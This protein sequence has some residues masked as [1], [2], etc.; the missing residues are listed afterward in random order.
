MPCV[1]VCVC[2]CTHVLCSVMSDSATPQAVASWVPLSMK[3]SRQE[4]WSE[5]PFPIPGDL[6]N[7]GN[8]RVSLLSLALAGKFFTTALAVLRPKTLGQDLLLLFSHKVVSDSQRP[9]GLQPTKAT[10][11]TGLPQVRVLAWAA[12]SFSKVGLLLLLL[13]LSRF[14]RV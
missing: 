7:P 3:F 9:H 6:S 4:Y 2:A 11:S 5:Q 12:I 10:L 14:S 13:L 8:E 1:C